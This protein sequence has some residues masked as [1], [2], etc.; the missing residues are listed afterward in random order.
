M[1]LLLL[2]LSLSDGPPVEARRPKAVPKSNVDWF[3][4]KGNKIV[5]SSGNEARLTG[6]N[7]FGYNTGT[8]IFDG[9]WSSNLAETVVNVAN[10]GF[11]LFRVPFSVQII[12]EWKRGF[13]ATM[14]M[15]PY[16]NEE[17]RGK[18]SLECWDFFLDRCRENGIK[19]MIDI[20]SAP[21]AASGHQYPLWAAGGFTVN[22]FYAAHAWI[23]ERYKNDDVIIAIDLKNEPHGKKEDQAFA[24]WDNS[25]DATNWKD[26]AETAAKKILA[27]NPNMLI[28]VEGVEIFT[29]DLVNNAD[30]HL[31]TT[32]WETGETNYY[33]T[34]WGGNLRGAAYFPLKGFET[35]LVYSPHDYGPTV[36]EQ[37]WFKKD[38]NYQTLMADVWHDNWFYLWE[39]KTA[40]LLI[41]EWGG[42]L[43][44]A[45][46][47]KWLTA[48]RQMIVDHG[49]SHT[50]WCLN[51]N[52]ADTGGLLK[53]DYKTWDEEKYAFV[54]PALWQTKDGKFIGLSSSVPLGKNG[55][56][57]PK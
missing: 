27:I 37:V 5:D 4:V 6:V 49:L 47:K 54:K 51:P 7:W 20:H 15:N 39:N 22:D 42:F 38:F 3:S 33:G 8:N 43:T 48:M 32:I 50:F 31:Q 2:R 12:L 57:R 16:L 55:I 25:K 23:V 17:L 1:L 30:Y 53:D 18:N 14:N 41:G 46:T 28:M 9:I 21:S 29:K 11:N 24:K 34:W 35:K 56:T 13:Y 26:V 10:R 45:K 52:S 19:V 44:D 40:P 36:F